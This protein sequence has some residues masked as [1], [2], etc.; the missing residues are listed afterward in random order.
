MRSDFLFFSE[1]LRQ[2]NAY[3]MIQF[4]IINLRHLTGK[5]VYIWLLKSQS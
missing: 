4:V 5:Y 2:R 3:L 1:N